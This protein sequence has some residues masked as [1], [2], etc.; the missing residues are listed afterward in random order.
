MYCFSKRRVVGNRIVL[1]PFTGWYER[2]LKPFLWCLTSLVHYTH[3]EIERPS[4][5][6]FFLLDLCKDAQV[7]TAV[8]PLLEL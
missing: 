8:K 5:K 4:E 2:Y 6:A 3:R 1:I 7:N